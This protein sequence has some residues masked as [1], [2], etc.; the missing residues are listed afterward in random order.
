MLQK[1]HHSLDHKCAE[2]SAIYFFTDNLHLHPLIM[3]IANKTMQRGEG[4]PVSLFDQ[5]SQWRTTGLGT[6]NQE[7]S[8]KQV[9]CLLDIHSWMIKGK[10]SLKM[11]FRNFGLHLILL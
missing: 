2:N 5:D 11:L 9:S 7:C 10:I 6:A 3:P 4:T 1:S 8:A